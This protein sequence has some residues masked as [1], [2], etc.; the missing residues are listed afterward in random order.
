MVRNTK[1]PLTQYFL[2]EKDFAEGYQF[3]D[4]VINVTDIKVISGKLYNEN[5]KA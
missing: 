5:N 4:F 1:L 2:S 3:T